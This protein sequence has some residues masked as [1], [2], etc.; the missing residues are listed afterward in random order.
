MRAKLVILALLSAARPAAAQ[1]FSGWFSAW[2]Q[3]CRGASC[4]LPAPFALNRSA[5]LDLTPPSSPGEAAS[6]SV[7][8]KFHIDGAEFTAHLAVYAV[9]PYVAA[10]ARPGAACPGLYYQAQLTLSG[11]AEAFCSA[12]LN[13]ADALP[14]PVLTCAGRLS[15]GRRAGVTL[16]RRPY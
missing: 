14:W 12:A 10:G 11:P 2:T 9:C 16:H 15:P 8:E 4:S 7:S 1:E 6:A 13:S 3:D 5:R